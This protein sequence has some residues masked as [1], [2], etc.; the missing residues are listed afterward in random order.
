MEIK[1]ENTFYQAD[2]EIKMGVHYWKIILRRVVKTHGEG[3]ET[4]SANPSPRGD[5]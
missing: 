4:T 1:M 2:M 5:L 3:Q